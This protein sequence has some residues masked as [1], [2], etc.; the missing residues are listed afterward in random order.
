MGIEKR[1]SIRDP[2]KLPKRGFRNRYL[3]RDNCQKHVG[4]DNFFIMQ[5]LIS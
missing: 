2:P 3:L 4:P 1:I 5:E